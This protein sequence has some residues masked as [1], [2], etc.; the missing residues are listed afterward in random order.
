MISKADAIHFLNISVSLSPTTVSTQPASCSLGDNSFE[1]VGK[2]I[3]QESRDNLP[4]E[5]AMAAII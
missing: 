2:T 5:D 4:L 1:A 3:I